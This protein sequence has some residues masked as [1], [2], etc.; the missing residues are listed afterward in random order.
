MVITLQMGIFIGLNIATK[1]L[2]LGCPYRLPAGIHVFMEIPDRQ[3]GT[4]S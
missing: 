2:K 1:I 3:N 4:Q